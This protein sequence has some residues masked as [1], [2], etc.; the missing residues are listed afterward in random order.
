LGQ[1]FYGSNGREVQID[2]RLLTH[3]KIVI[4]SKLRRGES[5]AFTWTLEPSH[6]EGRGT[7]WLSPGVEVEFRFAGSREAGVNRAWIQALNATA[8][9]GELVVV[10]EPLDPRQGFQGGQTRL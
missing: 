6:G 4:L 8:E 7:V 9:R 3:L 2:D 10:S 1:F 5:F